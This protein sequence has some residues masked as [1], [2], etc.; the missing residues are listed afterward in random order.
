[1]AP[2]APSLS[3]VRAAGLAAAAALIFAACGASSTAAPAATPAPAATAA[4][5]PAATA[6]P[7]GPA[8]AA[9][10]S[11]YRVTLASDPKLGGYLAGEDGKSLYLFTKDSKD[12]ATCAGGCAAAWPPFVLEGAETVAAGDGVTGALATITRADGGKQVTYNGVP[13][14]YFAKD[15]QAGDTKGQGL[16]NVWF[17][18]APGSGAQ[19]GAIT[20]GVGQGAPPATAPSPATASSPAGYSADAGA[21]KSTITI[22]DFAFTPAS[23]TVKVGATV[24]WTNVGGPTHTATADNGAFDSGNIAAGATFSQTFAT[25]GTFAFHCAIHHS[26]TGSITVTP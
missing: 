20:G 9:S 19:G 23:L 12:T 18:V 6:A 10:A 14:Y 15:A 5:A 26:M 21:S 17:L 11:V 7:T 4:A 16:N 22:K 24:T 2:T 25:A 8:S 3:V 1:M 13:L